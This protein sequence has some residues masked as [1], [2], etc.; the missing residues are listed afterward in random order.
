LI[1]GRVTVIIP[2]CNEAFLQ[3]TIDSL[4]GNAHGD[5]EILAVI[6]G[7]PWPNPPLKTDPRVIVLRHNESQG[8]RQ[9]TNAA[10]QIAT[11]EFLMKC[12]GHCIFGPGW[13]A[14]LK[15]D[16]DGDWLAV[17]T[18]HSI[19]GE[20]WKAEGEAAAVNQRHYN[21]H[22]LT[23]PYA[24]SMYGY[25]LH[26]KTFDWRL[27]RDV[28]KLRRSVVVDDLLSFQGSCWFMHTANFLRLGP[29]DHQ[30]YY[31]Y[32]ESIEVGLRQWISGGRCVINKGTWY[33]HYHKGPNDLHTIDG[34]KGRGFYLSLRKKRESEAYATDYWM[35]DKMPGAARTFA[36]LLDRFDWM[37]A[38][39]PGDDRWPD[40]WADPRHR[41]DFLNRPP[42]QVPAHL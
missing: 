6:D 23:F 14:V 1:K 4:L 39:I 30:H 10:A 17:P 9:S 13:D 27:N 36:Q 11:G 16:C 18:R 2:A 42:D 38:L 41:V 28:N 34:R 24:P 7:G 8:M 37:T 35:G 33:A 32:A 21:Y 15:A 5:V 22:Y 19:N 25:G 20:K 12:D 31:F 26:G 40:D 29:L 3:A